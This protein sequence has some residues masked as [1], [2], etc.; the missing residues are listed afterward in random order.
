MSFKS[1]H[2]NVSTTTNN[3]TAATASTINT[4]SIL[5]TATNTALNKNTKDNKDNGVSKRRD[6]ILFAYQ[7]RVD[8]ILKRRDESTSFKTIIESASLSAVAA[9]APPHR[10]SSIGTGTSSDKKVWTDWEESM[11]SCPR[12]KEGGRNNGAEQVDHACLADEN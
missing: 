3:S 9:S 8:T 11:I 2:V 5:N 4:Q 6:E 7:G 12:T 1:A 10:A